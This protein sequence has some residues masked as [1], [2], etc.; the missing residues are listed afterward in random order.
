[1]PKL[2]QN[3]TD[4]LLEREGGREPPQVGTQQ[5]TLYVVDAL[6]FP[7]D[8]MNLLRDAYG[9]RVDQH[10]ASPVIGTTIKKDSQ[11]YLDKFETTLPP[12]TLLIIP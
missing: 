10:L 8:I 7:F 9:G 6:G 4:I 3:D 1:M 11:D 2:S 5:K 12:E